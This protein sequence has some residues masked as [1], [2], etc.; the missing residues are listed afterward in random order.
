[1]STSAILWKVIKDFQTLEVGYKSV[2]LHG[3]QIS[4][5]FFLILNESVLLLT[6]GPK[7]VKLVVCCLIS[8]LCLWIRCYSHCYSCSYRRSNYIYTMFWK[9]FKL[10]TGDANLSNCLCEKNDVCC[11]LSLLIKRYSYIYTFSY[12]IVTI[13]LVV[14]VTE[15]CL[16]EQ[17]FSLYSS[18]SCFEIKTVLRTLA[19]VLLRQHNDI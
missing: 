1:M 9:V 13:T 8:I 5:E 10:L 12:T 6:R 15:N 2:K 3:P 18:I 7:S 17:I 16:R 14:T 4:I 19:C 11:L